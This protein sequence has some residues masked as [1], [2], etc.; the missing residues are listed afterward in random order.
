M[1]NK[2]QFKYS[3]SSWL[4]FIYYGRA[5][6]CV[7]L[8]DIPGIGRPGPRWHGLKG[9]S[10][11]PLQIF[12]LIKYTSVVGHMW[13]SPHLSW[14]CSSC[15]YS[16]PLVLK[17]KWCFGPQ[18]WEEMDFLLFPTHI[19]VLRH[20]GHGEMTTIGMQES[21]F[22]MPD[23]KILSSP[24]CYCSKAVLSGSYVFFLGNWVTFPA[25]KYAASHSSS[26]AFPKYFA[27]C[28]GVFVLLKENII[29]LCPSAGVALFIQW[30]SGSIILWRWTLWIRKRS[31][32]WHIRPNASMC[33]SACVCVCVCTLPPTSCFPFAF[34]PLYFGDQNHHFSR[35]RILMTICVRRTMTLA[36]IEKL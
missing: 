32:H 24:C 7:T 1:W 27:V 9:Q 15:R 14:G 19:R 18:W 35:L 23:V 11:A 5:L 30:P 16:E 10:H 28:L 3:L 17:S 12:H 2:I 26:N 33:V 8:T 13:G 21:P 6:R 29:V 22:R 25:L 31:L 34:A 20:S 36:P 4:W